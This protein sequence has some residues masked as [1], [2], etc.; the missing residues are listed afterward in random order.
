[1]SIKAKWKLSAGKSSTPFEVGGRYPEITVT[2]A[3]GGVQVQFVT[4]G[5]GGISDG[6]SGVVT[7]ELLEGNTITREARLVTIT[8]GRVASAGSYEVKE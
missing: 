8:A 5:H 7:R 1:M 2:C 4:D 3:K 6:G